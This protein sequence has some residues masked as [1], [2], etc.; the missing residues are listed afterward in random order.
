M[1]EIGQL[2]RLQAAVGLRAALRIIRGW[3]ATPGQ[4]CKIL[5]ISASTYRRAFHRDDSTFRLDQDQQQR[6]GLV[7]GIHA[8]LR[9][10]FDNPANV[11]GFPRFKNE[12][13]FFEGRSPLEIMSQGDM[14]SLYETYRRIEQ[15]TRGYP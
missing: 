5:R 14:I 11:R 1:S 6:L 8:A 10:I 13:P 7:L 4:A 15:L 9:T 2:N 12:N 3:Q